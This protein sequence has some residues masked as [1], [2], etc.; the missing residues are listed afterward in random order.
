MIIYKSQLSKKEELEI[1]GILSEII[2]EYSDFY[3]TRDNIR[4]YIKDNIDILISS[5]KKGD[6]I[7]FSYEEGIAV[8]D[9]YSDNANRKY[10]KI[11]ARDENSANKLLKVLNH[12]IKDILFAKIKKN[13]PLLKIFKNNGF[14]FKGSRGLEELLIKETNNAQ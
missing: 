10:V 6:K 9:G 13:S 1:S 8:V 2:D 11:L 7:A 4:L 12:N 14:K 3:L 5:L